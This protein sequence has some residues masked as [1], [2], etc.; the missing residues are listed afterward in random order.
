MV[1]CEERNSNLQN[2]I[3]KLTNDHTEVIKRE[4]TLKD[5]LEKTKRFYMSKQNELQLQIKK[6]TKENDRLKEMLGKDISEY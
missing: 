4:N 2:K 5:E 6:L 3:I 1:K